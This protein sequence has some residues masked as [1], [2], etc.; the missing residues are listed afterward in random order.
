M[1]RG[2]TV[3]EILIT[4]VIMAILLTLGVVSLRN[5][6]AEARDKER[7]TDIDT[8]ARGLE[9]R[10]NE[11]NPVLVSAT[12]AREGKQ[13]SYPG[14]NEML[15][16]GGEDRSG[17]GFNPAQVTGGY[18]TEG[19]PGTSEAAFTN[20]GGEKLWAIVCVWACAPAGDT[21]QINTAFNNQDKYV[22]EPIDRSGNICCCG[23]CPGFNLYWKTETNGALQTLKSKNR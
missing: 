2:F 13:G 4:L 10:Y 5:V 11:G 16:M 19:L 14:T 23:D 8:I 3:V 15:H 9:R 1:K 20:P 18:L 22:Y 12:D 7:A 21:T 6:Q 17:Q